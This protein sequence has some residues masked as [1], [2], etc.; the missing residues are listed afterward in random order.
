MNSSHHS[1][2]VAILTL[3]CCGVGIGAETNTDT[4]TAVLL[5]GRR[6]GLRAGLAQVLADMKPG[7]P[8]FP[9]VCIVEDKDYANAYRWNDTPV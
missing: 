7:F 2:S 1:L 4:N 5:L 6:N 3:A 8:R 9:G